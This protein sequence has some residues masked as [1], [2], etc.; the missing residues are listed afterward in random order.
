[1]KTLTNQPTLAERVYEA[2]LT[3]IAAGKI[4]A[5]A[6][7]IQ[8]QI[9]LELGVSRQP[10]QQALALLRS[11]GVLRD[12]PGRG[13]QVAPID[14]DQV[15]HMSELR[16]VIEGLAC[17]RAAE[18]GSGEAARRGPALIEAGRAA[19]AAGSV[20]PMI[21]ADMAL[22]DFIYELSDNPL[23]APALE[24][25]WTMMQRVMGQVLI[26]ERNPRDIWDQHEEIIAAIA[27]ADGAAA[28]ALARDHILNSTGFMLERLAEAA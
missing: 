14:H 8:E 13:L 28:E 21:A 12:A 20:G 19:V 27:A 26:R 24:T 22:H 5:G 18:R 23:I 4:G 25:H 9:A 7:I 1:M 17:R 15:R 10:V 16:A 2:I 3:E 11:Q 6:R